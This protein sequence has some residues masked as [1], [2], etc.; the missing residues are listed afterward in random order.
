M[1][2]GGGVSFHGYEGDG[3]VYDTVLSLSP[4]GT[5]SSAFVY[6]SLT[7][8]KSTATSKRLLWIRSF[9]FVH[10][11]GVSFLIEMNFCGTEQSCLTTR[12][13]LLSARSSMATDELTFFND[14]S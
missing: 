11:E 2:L 14:Y 9:E 10:D 1:R 7:S 6:M 8:L 13:F 3:Y 5:F 12:L 4:K